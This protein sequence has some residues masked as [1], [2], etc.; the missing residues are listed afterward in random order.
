NELLSHPLILPAVRVESG[1]DHHRGTRLA[2]WTPDAGEYFEIVRTLEG[3]FFHR[4]LLV[5][6]SKD[7]ASQHRAHSFLAPRGENLIEPERWTSGSETRLRS[8]RAQARAL[9]WRSSRR[10]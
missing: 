4:S 8:S 10:W 7:Y 5:C 3:L 9:A 2:V 1:H 6:Q